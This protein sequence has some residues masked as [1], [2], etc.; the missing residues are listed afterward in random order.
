MLFQ[1]ISE[2]SRIHFQINTFVDIIYALILGRVDI[3][4]NP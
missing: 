4:I 1:Q 3:F 2:K